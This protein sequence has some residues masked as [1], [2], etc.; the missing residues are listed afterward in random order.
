MGIFGKSSEEKSA[1]T[2]VTKKT[3]DIILTTLD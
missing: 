2:T 3:A 1:E